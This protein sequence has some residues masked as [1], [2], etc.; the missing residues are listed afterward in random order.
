MRKDSS[1]DVDRRTFMKKAAATGT[2]AVG[3]GASSGTA[4]ASST[5]PDQDRTE[6]LLSAHADEVLSQL[7]RDGVLAD[8]SALPTGVEND[9][10]GVAKGQ[11]GAAKLIYSDGSE[12]IRVVK[13]VE[14]GTLTITVQPD[15]E[16]A[17]ASLDTESRLVRYTPDRGKYDVSTRLCTCT[18]DWC[19]YP[20]YKYAECCDSSGCTYYCSCNA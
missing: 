5:A 15:E 10:A 6:F 20:Y 17:F 18:N 8:G 12:E 3:V 9:F 19:D 7:E 14:A 2:V 13:Q 11:E 4:V 16:Y 1:V